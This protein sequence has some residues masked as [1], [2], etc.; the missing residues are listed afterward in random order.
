MKDDNVVFLSFRNDSLPEP[1]TEVSVLS[2]GSCKNKTWIVK[3]D[4]ISKFPVL[5]CAVCQA[6]GG[7]IGWVGGD[8]N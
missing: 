4:Q 5:Q 2:C 3:Y 8:D 1:S 6:D 7:R